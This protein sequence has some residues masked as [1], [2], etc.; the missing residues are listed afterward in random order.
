MV[1]C[2]VVVGAALRLGVIGHIDA[3]QI[4]NA[5][6]NRVEGLITEDTVDLDHIDPFS[7]EQEI[8]VMRPRDYGPVRMFAN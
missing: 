7:P 8:A 4:F 2:V 1:F 3:Q 5:T 6:R